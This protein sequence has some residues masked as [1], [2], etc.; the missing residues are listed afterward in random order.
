MPSALQGKKIALVHDWLTGMRGGEKCLEVFC[1][2][3]PE[4]D[5][6]T[7]FHEKGAVSPGIERMRRNT[8]FIQKMPAALRR[9]YPYYLPFFP[10]AA[11]RFRLKG[12]D[13]VLSSSHC[14]AKGVRCEPRAFH[15]SYVHAPMR[16]VW[17]S[18]DLYFQREQSRTGLR[19]GARMFRPFLQEWDRRSSKGVD[20]FLCNSLNV[21][22]QIRRHYQRDARVVYPP[23]DLDRFRPGAGKGDHYLMVGA[24]V[25]N[26]RVDLAVMAFNRLGLRLKI[27]GVGWDEK[28]CRR[29][30][31]PHVEFLGR[32][33]DSR[34]AELYQ[35]ARAFVFPGID[36][37][38]IT[39]LEAQ[40]CGTPVIAYAKGGALETVTPDTGIFFYEPTVE[41]LMEAVG[42]METCWNSFSLE[43][44]VRN[45]GQF[46]RERFR[47]Q[48]AEAVEEGYRAWEERRDTL[49]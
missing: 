35:T 8:S 2:L 45:A 15:V 41:S 30:A 21:Q 26:K 13:I 44:L 46:G 20:A 22:E 40:A 17:D 29:M 48:I 23:V 33:D 37:F 27:V 1:E 42:Q 16:Y 19:L 5:L 47:A 38:G 24:L 6:F 43:D 7:L 36:D 25:P 9:R 12:Y 49:V 31:A 34:L 18:F 3:Y 10:L 4:A 14:V 39:P 28:H 32:V 11:R